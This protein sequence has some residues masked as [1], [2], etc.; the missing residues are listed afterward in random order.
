MANVIGVDIGGTQ[1]RAGLFDFQGRPL[2]LLEG[3][4]VRSGGREWMLRQIRDWSQT[5]LRKSETHVKGCGISFGGPVDFASQRVRSIHTPGWEDFP[6][7][8]WFTENLG[9]PC[10]VDNDANCG[11]LGEY[12]FGAGRGSQSLV[13]LTISTGIGGGIVWAGKVHRGKDSFAGEFGHMPMADSHILCS[14]GAHGCLETFCSGPAIARRA[15]ELAE[16]RPDAMGRLAELCAN[17]EDITTKVVF[18]AAAE[19]DIAAQQ[20]V[21]EAARWLA[22]A[23]LM[24]IRILNPDKIVLGGGVMQAEEIFLGP[25][26]TYLREM[27]TSSI[28]YSTELQVSELGQN[29]QLYGAAA[30]VQDL[31]P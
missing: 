7:A 14:C 3:D 10:R 13:F 22:R 16:R 11:A 25:I 20:I 30:L 24:V 12:C 5:L 18:Q 21:N 4:T 26:R 17:P 23:L 31:L 9:L 19:G 2:H 1:C 29:A 6:L 27:S 15:Q 28:G 8:E